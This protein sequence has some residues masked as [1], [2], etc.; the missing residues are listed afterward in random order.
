MRHYKLKTLT[1]TKSGF[2]DL[3]IIPLAD[4]VTNTTTAQVLTALQP[5]DVVYKVLHEVK[6]FV[7]GPATATVSIGV[8]GT[9][10][11]FTAASDVKAAPAYVTAIAS[12]TPYVAT[13]SA[14]NMVANEI[15]GAGAVTAGELWVWAN[16]SRVEDRGANAGLISA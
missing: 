5:G 4:W 12:V 15:L 14:I 16:I 9:L 10:T 11:Q 13:P 7:A 3:F 2:T 8:V 6:I 1:E